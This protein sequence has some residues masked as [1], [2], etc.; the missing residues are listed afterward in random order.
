VPVTAVAGHTE[1]VRLIREG[2]VQFVINTPTKGKEPGRLGFT[3][4]RTAAEFRVPC[5]TSLD[6][7]AAV[8]GIID[9]LRRGERPCPV[10]MAEFTAHV[11]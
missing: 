10:S 8:V 6:T 1:T 9:F 7:A 4:R 3:I 11:Q 5:F 2:R